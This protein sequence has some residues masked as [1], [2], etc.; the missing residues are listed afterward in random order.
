MSENMSQL[1][2]QTS[3]KLNSFDSEGETISAFGLTQVQ[4][5]AKSKPRFVDFASDYSEVYKYVIWVTNAVIP[6][7]FWGT[8]ANF[9]LVCQR[10]PKVS[11]QSRSSS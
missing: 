9:R 7:S 11:S 5:A 4:K 1:R 8:R 10:K 2:S 3:L 6:K